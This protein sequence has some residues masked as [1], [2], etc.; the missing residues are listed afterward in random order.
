MRLY[1]VVEARPVAIV[2]LAREQARQLGHHTICT[3]HLLLALLEPYEGGPSD[4]ETFLADHRCLAADCRKTLI[5]RVGV[6]EPL[7]QSPKGLSF[8]ATAIIRYSEVLAKTQRID[9][10]DLLLFYS[11]LMDEDC[12][13]TIALKQLGID[14]E[15]S[16]NALE[17]RWGENRRLRPRTFS[18]SDIGS[19]QAESLHWKQKLLNAEAF[20]S[21]GLVGQPAAIKA[22]CQGLMRAWAGMQQSGRPLASLL[23]AGPEGSGKMTA[24]L[25]LAE[26]LFDSDRR[27]YR[28]DLNG[29]G[30]MAQFYSLVGDPNEKRAG[31]LGDMLREYPRSLFLFENIDRAHPR[32]Q[33][34]IRDIV[35]YGQ[36]DD[37][38]GQRLD[39][40]E[41]LIVIQHTFESSEL[42]SV[43]RLGFRQDDSTEW[44]KLE[45]SLASQLMP[46]LGFDLFG[47]LD[48]IVAFRALQADDYLQLVD[49]WSQALAK[50]MLSRR[51][52]QLEFSAEALK[53]LANQAQ[54]KS[55]GTPFLQRAF[56]REVENSLA[57]A[58]LEG[59][60]SE[61]QQCVLV[62]GQ[63]GGPALDWEPAAVAT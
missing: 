37:S 20:L 16:M 31:C 60:I 63:E 53:W 48:G 21:K 10:M 23:F 57:R 25:K 14:I 3:E 58:M 62:L 36:I 46:I 33:N 49:K 17:E 61:G 1:P 59:R 39:F 35:T 19:H 12:E 41:S 40:R 54:G 4:C 29:Y 7:E 5:E 28:F 22:I 30:E 51:S 43:G 24:A 18:G 2:E 55:R 11:I 42:G 13:T 27:L 47:V 50:K 44:N 32:V 34:L 45:E 9:H 52:I 26:F 8:R 15:Q 56:L 38:F 6:A